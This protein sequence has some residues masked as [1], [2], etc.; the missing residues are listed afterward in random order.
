MRSPPQ[1]SS[2]NSAFVSGDVTIDPNAVIA[3]GAILQANP[4]A[5]II[6]AAGVCVGM[7]AILHAYNGTL[8]VETGVSIGAR[9][10]IRGAVN[11]GANSCIGAEAT[12][13]DCAI[14]PSEIVPARALVGDQSRQVDLFDPSDSAAASTH[15][16]TAAVSSLD[17]SDHITSNRPEPTLS[18]T[19]T[20]T[21]AS[22]TEISRPKVYGKENLDQLL[23]TL[24]P[25]RKAL[26]SPPAKSPSA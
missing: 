3:P 11:I 17:S 8:A 21:V 1:R 6:I 9:A 15:S 23:D 14:A 12:I 22:D 4:E 7:G 2:L 5:R 26:K 25:H 16:K 18:P 24:L 20:E 19:S 13:L 10:L